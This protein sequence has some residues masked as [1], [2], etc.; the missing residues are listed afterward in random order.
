MI[1]QKKKIKNLPNGDSYVTKVG[2]FI[3]GGVIG[4]QCYDFSP[5][6]VEDDDRLSIVIFSDEYN[7]RLVR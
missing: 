3:E 6:D 7:N 5:K 4:L 1:F 2:Y